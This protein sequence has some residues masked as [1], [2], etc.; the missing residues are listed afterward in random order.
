MAKRNCLPSDPSGHDFFPV[1]THDIPIFV[2]CESCGRAVG[3]SV[4][5]QFV[6]K[7]PL[8]EQVIA[9]RLAGMRL[10]PIKES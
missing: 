5:D 6:N 10:A 1:Y 2:V 9:D 7:Y 4:E 8:P 3:L